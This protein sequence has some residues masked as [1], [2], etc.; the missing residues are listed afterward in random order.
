MVSRKGNLLIKLPT[1][2]FI[3]LVVLWII[4]SDSK[5]TNNF[6]HALSPYLPPKCSKYHNPPL[7]LAS[8]LLR[9]TCHLQIMYSSTGSQQDRSQTWGGA[10][11]GKLEWGLAIKFPCHHV[12]GGGEFLGNAQRPPGCTVLS[13]PLHL[14]PGGNPCY[15]CPGFPPKSSSS[16][17]TWWWESVN[18]LGNSPK[19]GIDENK[20][21]LGAVSNEPRCTCCFSSQIHNLCLSTDN[22]RRKSA[23]PM[24]WYDSAKQTSGHWAVMV[25]LWRPCGLSD[26]LHNDICHEEGRPACL[27]CMLRLSTVQVSCLKIADLA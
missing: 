8:Y 24:H 17:A 13:D 23:W 26:M 7:P 16:A 20:V 19:G 14:W 1:F 22:I 9:C 11:R 21:S 27:T 10:K 12:V 5:N 18:L 6:M 4:F 15:L 2:N 25:S 3:L